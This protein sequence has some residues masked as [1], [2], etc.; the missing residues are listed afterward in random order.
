MALKSV[1]KMALK[2]VKKRPASQKTFYIPGKTR[3]KRTIQRESARKRALAESV[4]ARMAYRARRKRLEKTGVLYTPPDQKVERVRRGRR[5]LKSFVTLDQ[6]LKWGDKAA[7]RNLVKMKLLKNPQKATCPGCKK[8]LGKVIFRRGRHPS[9]RCQRESC[10]GDK[11]IK[12]TAGTWADHKNPLNKLAAVAFT[13]C[14]QLSR[15]PAEDD[16]AILTGVGH[17]VCQSVSKKLLGV[18]YKQH[19]K[20]QKKIRLAGQCEGDATT[21]RV[22]RLRNG[23]LLHVRVFGLSR[24]GDHTKTIVEMM[25]VYTTPPGGKTRPESRQEVDSIIA[26]HMAGRGKTVWHADGAR[27]YRHQPQ[28]TRVKHCK[29]IYCSVRKLKMLSGEVLVCYG[30]TQLQDGL[31]KHLKS[32]VPSTMNT[33]SAHMR[34]KLDKWVAYWAWRYRRASKVDMFRELGHTIASVHG[35]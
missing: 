14:G 10:G 2:P 4:K 16:T 23:R 18:I 1:K 29:R 19:Q 26:K 31:W 12:T 22:V 35:Y 8:K 32:H 33:S 5:S 34:A 27:C 17:K 6:I 7:F 21:L 9:Q 28:N 3:V 24:R 15:R 11:W 20:E 30:G 25:P 13:Q